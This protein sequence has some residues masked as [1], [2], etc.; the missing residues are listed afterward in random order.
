MPKVVGFAFEESGAAAKEWR[1]EGHSESLTY[2]L[3]L[4]GML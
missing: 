4:G 3:V 1:G 2:E